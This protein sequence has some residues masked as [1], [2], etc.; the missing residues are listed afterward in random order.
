MNTCLQKLFTTIDEDGSGAIDSQELRVAL[1]QLKVFLTDEEVRVLHVCLHLCLWV[2][3][4][5]CVCEW[6]SVCFCVCDCVFLYVCVCVRERQREY[7]CIYVYILTYCA[8]NLCAHI[9]VEGFPL[10]ILCG[11]CAC[12]L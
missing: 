3:V 11:C 6:V 8:C 12:A 1:M 7:I 9:E 5:A 2:C 4:C 10:E